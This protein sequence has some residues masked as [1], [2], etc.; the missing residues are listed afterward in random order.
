MNIMQKNDTQVI[1]IIDA[2]GSSH[3]SNT[4]NIRIIQCFNRG[5]RF[6]AMIQ[7]D[8]SDHDVI[9]YHVAAINILEIH[10]RLAC[11]MIPCQNNPQYQHIINDINSMLPDLFLIKI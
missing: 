11:D 6:I 7:Q 1:N 5:D 10:A 9:T 2:G 3:H 4:V 8:I